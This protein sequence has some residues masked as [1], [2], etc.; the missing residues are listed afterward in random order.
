M[1][2]RLGG[3]EFAL[4][5]PD[6]DIDQAAAVAERIRLLISESP[7]AT[8][9]EPVPVTIS[10]GVAQYQSEQDSLS[11]LLHRADQ[12]LLNAK[13]RGRNQVRVSDH[14]VAASA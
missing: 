9:N 1:S 7:L 3:D 11:D 12:Q 6:T 14:R 4:L 8:S 10:L 5:L 13:R 2:A